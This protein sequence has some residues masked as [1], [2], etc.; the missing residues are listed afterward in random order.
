MP[1]VSKFTFDFIVDKLSPLENL[2][3][4]ASILT[5]RI[6]GL[7]C[8]TMQKD[9]LLFYE[10]I[11]VS[12]NF[13]FTFLNGI[14]FSSLNPV[15]VPL[16]HEH[17]L[18]KP[19]PLDIKKLIPALFN[20]WI[21]LLFRANCLVT[22]FIPI[23]CRQLNFSCKRRTLVILIENTW[24]EILWK[25]E[26]LFSVEGYNKIRYDWC[27]YATRNNACYFPDTLDNPGV[28]QYF[29]WFRGGLK[30]KNKTCFSPWSNNNNN[31]NIGIRKELTS[32]SLHK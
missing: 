27:F 29:F 22:I 2:E 19:S 17:F 14:I 30:R 21:I 7:D 4:V 9:V 6:D 12:F 18:N 20:Y 31:N 11:L 24:S 5:W 15:P 32:N 1:T 10:I 25:H 16:K 23:S 8:T 28:K 26:L 13:I 3:N